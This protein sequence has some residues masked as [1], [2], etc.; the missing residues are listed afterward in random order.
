MEYKTIQLTVDKSGEKPVLRC[1]DVV[2]DYY[3]EFYDT[4]SIVRKLNLHDRVIAAVRPNIQCKSYQ[5]AYNKALFGLTHVSQKTLI[6]LLKGKMYETFVKDIP[7][8]IKMR[9]C[10]S[11]KNGR[12]SPNNVNAVNKALPLLKQAAEDGQY[13]IMPYIMEFNLPPDKLREMFGK[14]LW[15]KLCSFTLSRNKLIMSYAKAVPLTT[16]D[17]YKPKVDARVEVIKICTGMPSSLLKQQMDIALTRYFA[18]HCTGFWN[19]RRDLLDRAVI[20]QD[21]L[22]MHSELEEGSNRDPMT[23][24]YDKMKMIHDEYAKRMHLKKYP[25]T[26]FYWANHPVLEQFTYEGYTVTPLLSE[27]DIGMEGEMMRH[28]VGSYAKLSAVGQYLVYSVTKGEEKHSTIGFRMT[29]VDNI[30]FNVTVEQHYMRFNARVPDGDPAAK[31]PQ[32][33]FGRFLQLDRA[34]C[35]S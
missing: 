11:G 12:L 16:Q 14:G 6:K 26:R 35:K 30:P 18:T 20:I 2:I 21:T 3:Q 28:C 17:L 8:S 1:G 19:K 13:N 4:K 7:E 25:T 34:R 22:R 24:S 27:F 33:I 5:A 15:K 9:L 31:I 10:F 32:I 23:W 29:L